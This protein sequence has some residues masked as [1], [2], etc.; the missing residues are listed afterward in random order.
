MQMSNRGVSKIVGSVSAAVILAACA[1]VASAAPTYTN[2][3]DT[4]GVY[5][6]FSPPAIANDGTV[7]VRANRDAGGSA[8]VAFSSSGTRVLADTD[9]I[10]SGFGVP[11]IGGDG[12]IAFMAN[13]DAGGTALLKAAPSASSVTTVSNT[14]GPILNYSFNEIHVSSNGRLTYLQRLDD[15]TRQIIYD[16][17]VVADGTVNGFSGFGGQPSGNAVGQAA[18]TGTQTVNGREATFRATSAGR[19]LVV[20]ANPAGPYTVLSAAP[21]INDSGDILIAATELGVGRGL[22][23]SRLTGGFEKVIDISGIVGSFG[24]YVLTNDDR[25]VFRATL[26]G[27]VGGLYVGTDLVAGKVIQTGDELFDSNV[28]TTASLIQFYRGANDV[29]QIAFGYSLLDGRSGIAIAVVPEPTIL[30]GTMAGILLAC[31]RVKR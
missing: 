15:N 23:I 2:V 24:S 27:G 10:Y 7:V 22:F 4:T 17:A 9:G 5:S 25:V 20:E 11:A 31:R 21:T 26:D 6:S 19:T 12:T 3:V 30:A 28:S 8:I 14:D 1:G 16:G 13:R 18:L 29:G